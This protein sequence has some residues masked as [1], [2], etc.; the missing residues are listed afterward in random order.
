MNFDA[1]IIGFGKAG[2]TL[3]S[4]LAQKGEKVALIE[5][6]EQMYGGTCINIG[7]IPTKTLVHSAHLT[8]RDAS[9][10]EKRGYFRAAVEHKDDVVHFLREKNFQKLAADPNVSIFLGV[11]SFVGEDAVQVRGKDQVL[12]LTAPKIF[13]NTG[14][15][16][17]IPEI[18]GVEN[19]TRVFTSTSL[20]NLTELPQV[21]TIVGGGYIGLEFASMFAS[22]GS[23]VTVLE[24]GAQVLPREDRD[25]AAAV[26]GILE[27]KGVQFKTHVQVTAIEDGTVVYEDTASGQI[28]R[29]EGDAIL[30][31][32]GR[33]PRTE[34]LQLEKAG[35]TV[36]AR[37]AIIVD[38]HL[39]TTNPHVYALGDVKGGPLFTYIS[40]DDFRIVRD[41][42]Y[43]T[44]DRTTLD[45][46]PVSTT[47]FI[48]PPLAHIGLT[49][50]Q[51]QSSG[52]HIAV[53]TLPVAA[54][55]RARTLQQTE[56]L[57][58]I[59]VDADTQEILGC[60]LLGPDAG[61]VINT[62]A[63]AMKTGQ[64]YT[65]LRDFIFTHPS[66][67]EALNDLANF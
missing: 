23:Q 44:V 30:L 51:A 57:F 4:F 37:G 60:T 25:I 59:V 48:D 36:N 10:E 47:V 53:N 26:Q 8:R 67:S 5:R 17:V 15:E 27:K 58:K 34:D 65:F 43:G 63:V 12:T 55:P 46:E 6:S 56:G 41:S 33:R 31:A 64:K 32:A 18:P 35:V 52:R 42:L 38:E 3:A 1:I 7:C 62:V 45:R 22:F 16:T 49:A 21:L 14:S 28:V 40:L 39:R 29:L 9:W 11:G 20:L 2:K 54:I 24:K 13:V 50:A 61:E 66:M 19:N